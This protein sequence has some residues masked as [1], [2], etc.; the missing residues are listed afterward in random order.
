MLTVEELIGQYPNQV[1]LEFSPQERAAAWPATG[2][3]SGDAAR[4]NAYLNRLVLNAVLPWL[5]EESGTEPA[6][7]PSQ[8]ALPSIWEFING[9]AVTLG[10]TRIV[11]IPSEAIDIEEFCVPQEWVDIPSWN[12]N[13]YLAVQVNPDEGWL[14]VW[15]YATHEQLKRRG[16]YDQL[17]C[18][19]SLDREDVVDNIHVMWVARQLCPDEKVEVQPLP[20]LLR[21]EAEVLIAQLSQPALYFPRL[22]VEF[23]QWGALLESE[24]CRQQLY[25]SKNSQEG[26]IVPAAVAAAL[27]V[28]VNLSNWFQNV[29]EQGWQT[30]E[31]LFGMADPNLSF[32]FRSLEMEPETPVTVRDLID[33]ISTSSDEERQKIAAQRLGQ[34]GSGSDGA[35]AALVHLIRTTED[36]ETRW[37]AAESL[38]TIDPGNPALGV[39]RV[40][41]LGMQIAGHAVALMVALLPW[42][43]GKVA[44]LLRV[45]PL[46]GKTYLPRGLQLIVLD[47]EGETFLDTEARDADNYIQLKFGGD[48]GERF[49][50]R[51]AVGDVAITEDFV[52]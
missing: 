51:V 34:I 42:G 45:Y 21:D 18:T 1:W 43:E 23:E 52:I 38:R 11:L 15:G 40:T 33:L 48:R 2:D 14:R 41:D 39:Q 24:I 20:S 10:Q 36:E 30:I 19:Y 9:T 28:P 8:G 32:A 6:V 12:A 5:Q 4:W 35:S 25:Q 16:S 22:H 44:I 13:Y 3:Y 46:R 49:S 17:S 26:A 47:E 27:Q 31:E 50:V 7:W 29:F 37:A